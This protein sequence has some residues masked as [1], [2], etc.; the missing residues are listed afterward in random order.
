MSIS[1]GSGVE[2]DE[3]LVFKS[4]CSSKVSSTSRSL[5]SSLVSVEN[6]GISYSVSI[7]D[8]RF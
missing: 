1:P 3:A 6:P 2:C 8:T 5:S 7:P 4:F